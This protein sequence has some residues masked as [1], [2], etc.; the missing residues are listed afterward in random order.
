M[1][2]IAGVVSFESRDH[3]SQ[4]EHMR[5]M[6]AMIHHRGPTSSASIRIRSVRWGAH[7]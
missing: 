6:L 2:G 1:C 7:G 4:R 5:S 3:A